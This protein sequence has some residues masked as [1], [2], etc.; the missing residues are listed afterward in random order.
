MPPSSTNSAAV[1]ALNPAAKAWIEQTLP[2]SRTVPVQLPLSSAP[3]TLPGMPAY[4]VAAAHLEPVAENGP[5]VPMAS[6][7]KGS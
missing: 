3:R 6:P 5:V 1:P 4:R 7:G 2:D